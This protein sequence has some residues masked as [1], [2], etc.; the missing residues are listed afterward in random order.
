[1]DV[2]KLLKNKRTLLAGGVT[3]VTLVTLTGCGKADINVKMYEKDNEITAQINI[4]DDENEVSTNESK[5][6]V[7]D[8]KSEELN[9]NT[10]DVAVKDSSKGV[11]YELVN[12]VKTWKYYNQ[13]YGEYMDAGYSYKIPQINIDSA[14]AEKIN[15]KI[16]DKYLTQYNEAVE[17]RNENNGE[18]GIWYRI[19]YAYHIN[20]DVVSII[21]DSKGESEGKDRSSYN[22]NMKTGKEVT[23]TELLKIKGITEEEFPSKLS[24]ILT[25][26][27]RDM[28][29]GNIEPAE[30]MTAQYKRTTSLEN[31]SIDN[32][33]YLNVNGDLCVIVNRYNIAGGESTKII[34]DIDRGIIYAQD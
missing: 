33:M 20:G 1:M 26:T 16:K 13:Y 24:N 15:Q 23:N 17:Y 2:K 14:D 19:E 11:V 34:I 32:D 3:L 30:F 12:D 8:N 28:Y 9:K 27:L 10:K 22:I 7:T 25:E 6:E 18:T 31:C 21:I 4:T 29:T 5:N